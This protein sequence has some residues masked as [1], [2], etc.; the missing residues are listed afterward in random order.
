MLPSLMPFAKFK[1]GDKFTFGHNIMV[2]NL[3]SISH[4]FSHCPNIQPLCRLCQVRRYDEFY[5]SI[6][7][8]VPSSYYTNLGYSHSV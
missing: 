1:T 2:N 6:F 3:L 8:H 4:R 7:L 5:R